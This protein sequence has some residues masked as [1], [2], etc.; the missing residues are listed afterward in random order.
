MMTS[1]LLKFVLATLHHNSFFA[2][3]AVPKIQKLQ[4]S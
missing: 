1:L 2:V 4:L 3:V